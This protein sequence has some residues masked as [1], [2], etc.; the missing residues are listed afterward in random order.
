MD[1][2]LNSRLRRTTVLNSSLLSLDA[3]L[4]SDG[5]SYTT[6]KLAILRCSSH[7]H[8]VVTTC[9]S[10]R[11]SS[12]GFVGCWVG[13]WHVVSDFNLMSRLFS[14][15]IHVWNPFSLSSLWQQQQQQASTRKYYHLFILSPDFNYKIVIMRTFVQSFGRRTAHYA[16][17]TRGR[18]T[19]TSSRTSTTPTS[20]TTR[21]RPLSSLN[22]QPLTFT[23]T[24][25]RT[26]QGP[27]PLV[28]GGDLECCGD[29][30]DDD[31]T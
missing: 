30:V 31:G 28:A 9:V 12:V 17:T 26:I 14:P 25:T 10:A 1:Y 8:C 23:I 21:T 29:V 4:E 2:G 18:T 15:P 7:Q 24:T 20:T 22:M 3:L 11:G 6:L 13:G 27:R 5:C 16:R 19:Q